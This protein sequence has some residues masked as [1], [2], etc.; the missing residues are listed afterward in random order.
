MGRRIYLPN[1]AGID[2]QIGMQLFTDGGCILKNPSEIGGTW[3]YV[4]RHRAT[5][6]DEWEIIK[7]ESGVILPSPKYGRTISNNLTELYAIIQASKGLGTNVL[8]M[9]DSLVSMLRA[10]GLTLKYN[11]LPDAFVNEMKEQLST[12]TKWGYVLLSGHP[13][14][15]Q[16]ARGVGKRGTPCHELNKWCDEECSRKA[17]EV[18]G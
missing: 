1:A 7:R 5:H 14:T 11:G 16:L 9:T 17:A 12:T 2:A 6:S 15:K 3:A 13:T 8:C 4:V 18:T 10:S